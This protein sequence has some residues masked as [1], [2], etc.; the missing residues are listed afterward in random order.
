VSAPHVVSIGELARRLGVTARTLRYWEE[1]GLLCPREKQ[2]AAER[3]YTERTY[4]EQEV[5]RAAHIQQLQELLGLRLTEIR[6][7]LETEDTLERLRTAHRRGEIP[8]GDRRLLDEALQSAAS[9]LQRID[10][11]LQNIA[12]YREDLARR[13]QKMRRY[14][15]EHNSATNARRS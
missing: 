6:A 15:A 12:A 10:S 9:L 3:T 11:R 5:Q 14:A 4:T 13:L 1:I 2:G 7:V 8:P